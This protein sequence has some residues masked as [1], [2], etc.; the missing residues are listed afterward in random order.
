MDVDTLDT[1]LVVDNVWVAEVDVVD[2]SFDVE[3]EVEMLVNVVLYSVDGTVKVPGTVVVEVIDVVVDAVDD[4]V[5][6]VVV[7]AGV[8]SKLVRM[9]EIV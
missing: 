6:V 4:S 9:E 7:V 3:V 1:E 5:C 2:F 8:V